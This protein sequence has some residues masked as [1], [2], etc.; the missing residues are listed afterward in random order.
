MLLL[1]NLGYAH[2]NKD[3]LFDNLNLA[4]NDH[5]KL[6]LIG[7]N[8][9]GKSTLLKIMAGLL[10]PSTG[11]VVASSAPYYIPQHF[12]QY[13]DL[14]VAQALHINGKITALAEILDGQ[15]TD[16]NLAALDDDWTIEERSQEALL[17]WGLADVRL[18]QRLASL[19]GGQKTKVFLAGIAIHR[20]DIVLL[21]E[22][23]NHLDTA[24]RQ[25]LYDFIASSPSTV[26]V[27]SHDR[28]LLNLLDAVCELS[29]RG[30]ALYGG[31]YAFYAE[32]KQVESHALTQDVKARA[33]ALRK[34]REAE[35]EAL[36]RKHKQDARGK[37]SQDKAGLPAIVLGMMRNSAENSASR[38]KGIH[39]E[40]VGALAQELSELR[41]ELPDTDKMKF[42]F[43]QSA[44]H[45]GKV[46]FEAQ[47]LNHNYGPGLL[48]PDDL[49]FRLHSGERLA[50][51]G[52]NGSGKTTLIKLLLGE[53]EPT[54]GTLH[55][56]GSQA[57]FIDQDYSLLHHQLSV[58]EQAQQFNAAG[59]QEHEVKIRLA[60]FLFPQDYWDKPCSA[61]SGGEKMRLLLCCLMI[62]NQAPDLIV[63][64]EPTNN[65]DIQNLEI[66]TAALH[67]YHGTLVVV[68]H[69]E[70][71]LQQLQVERTLRLG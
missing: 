8:G 20:P 50:L 42:N 60:R 29:R 9:A 62:S 68:S 35:R 11:R 58:Y 17:H 61:L 66:L 46:L 31:N 71:F 53:L 5:Q 22:P 55:R 21:D 15:A 38:L 45:K 49:T 59:L 33:T 14:T 23:S 47:G 56:A 37:K 26:L 54:R 32:Q 43:D 63:L 51:H 39:A 19:S 30:L 36:E 40:K 64:D 48:W 69:D 4:V 65:L 16:A 24:G 28:K 18:T 67:D 70:Y 12:G 3:V 7:N 6:A 2:P 25:L 57:V 10:A 41:K 27:V 1:Q 44:L 52:P 34:A 13:D